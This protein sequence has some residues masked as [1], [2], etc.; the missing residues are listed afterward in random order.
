MFPVLNANSSFKTGH[1]ILFGEN[2]ICNLSKKHFVT[3]TTN[4]VRHIIHVSLQVFERCQAK[5]SKIVLVLE[6]SMHVGQYYVFIQQV[7]TCCTSEEV[8]LLNMKSARNV[9]EGFRFRNG[10]LD[11]LWYEGKRAI[12]V[13]TCSYRKDHST[14]DVGWSYGAQTIYMYDCSIDTLTIESYANEIVWHHVIYYAAVIGDYF[15][16]IHVLP[17][18]YS[19]VFGIMLKT[20]TTYSIRSGQLLTYYLLT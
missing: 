9:I 7:L 19:L 10:T 8:K 12:E 5:Q 14:H 15:H 13:T 3:R 17:D 11:V 16:L 6:A 20:E 18:S 4:W 2:L 1:V